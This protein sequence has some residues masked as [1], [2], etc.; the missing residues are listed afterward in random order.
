MRLKDSFRMRKLF[1]V[2]LLS[3]LLILLVSLS[4]GYGIYI[5]SGRIIEQEISR[6]NLSML[7]KARQAMDSRMRDIERLTMQI[8][9][10]T[11]ILNALRVYGSFGPEDQFNLYKA[12]EDLRHYMASSGFVTDI[13]VFLHNTGTVITPS[14]HIDGRLFFDL[15][16]GGVDIRYE[17]WKSVMLSSH[18]RNYLVFRR[19]DS[20]LNPQS[21]IVS[22]QS[23]PID[24]IR[25]PR[26]TI[27]ISI[28]GAKFR[29]V[30]EDIGW[31]RQGN[32]FIVNA[33]NKIVAASDIKE[34]SN[35]IASYNN[36]LFDTASGGNGIMY[37]TI[38]GN[39]TVIAYSKS[40]IADWKYISVIPY[41]VF[42]EKVE[43][44]R[45]LA[46]VGMFLT[47]FI[48]GASSY[49]LARKN[50]APIE[51]IIKSIR[52]K[53]QISQ[54]SAL[55]EYQ[56]IQSNISSMI[57][58]NEK[59]SKKLEEQNK[60]LKDNFLLKLLKGKLEGNVVATQDFTTYGINF[61]TNNFAIVIFRVEEFKEFTVSM[62]TNNDVKVEYAK[63]IIVG[64]VEEFVN[65]GSSVIILE[66]DEGMI[67]CIFSF[68]DM[69]FTANQSYMLN[70]IHEVK[71]F[72]DKNF[73]FTFSVALSNIHQGIQNITRAY[74]EAVEAMEYRVVTGSGSIISF[75]DVKKSKCADYHYTIETEQRLINCIK[76]GDFEKAS[77]ALMEV[78]SKNLSKEAFSHEMA[79]CLMFDLVSTIM[80]TAENMSDA[81]FLEELQP[82]K[83]LSDCKTVMEMKYKLAEVIKKVCEYNEANKSGKNDLLS[84]KVKDF[85]ALNYADVNL[86]V[87]MIGDKFGLTPS[88]LSKLF[89][90]Q[91]NESLPDHINKVRIEMAM[92][93]LRDENA[94]IFDIAQKVGYCNSNVFIRAF[95]KYQGITPGRFKEMKES[96]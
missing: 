12:I 76:I 58:E 91:T 38:N 67:T 36:K 59:I 28:D 27:A 47:L 85:I 83:S 96:S 84:C 63:F 93:F 32:V 60:E 31:V 43:Y 24:S 82:V 5:E 10:N 87:S 94:T 8:A 56:F 79:K 21:F 9:L 13:Y 42:W 95:K 71:E 70:I 80:K 46:W 7:D 64:L 65:K 72:I 62:K 53:A 26:G 1:V 81:S 88:Y 29:D 74:N 41:S 49:L 54:L 39:K 3:Y 57:D 35:F 61:H 75:K 2:W 90:E 52:K 44:I 77:G 23:V 25:N 50:Y 66:E 30:I 33:D 4:I 18:R 6:A 89:K 34:A 51:K 11:R 16:Y 15:R 86:G 73:D 37:H 20:S 92:R 68:K 22:V 48:G 17:E 55:N 45:F 14:T 69:E 40:K 78:F 19:E